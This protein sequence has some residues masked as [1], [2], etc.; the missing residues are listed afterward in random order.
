MLPLDVYV[1]NG[2]PIA[3]I[4][5][6]LIYLLILLVLTVVPYLLTSIGI[7]K[8]GKSLEVTKPWLAFI[9]LAN[10]Y[11]LGKIAERYIKKDGTKSAKFSKILLML[12]LLYFAAFIVMYVVF[13]IVALSK[14]SSDALLLCIILFYLA[15]WAA[16]VVYLVVYYVAL[17]RVF[18]IFS[19]GNATLFLILSLFISLACP[20]LIFVIRNNR[21]YFNFPA[22][23]DYVNQYK[24]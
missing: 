6:V 4:M 7:F 19:N 14:A 13:F 23:E 12:M 16:L 20:I 21:P 10:N 5:F 9:P 17:W 2:A 18:A 15:F 3:I 11:A 22:E 8:M 1:Q 24:Y